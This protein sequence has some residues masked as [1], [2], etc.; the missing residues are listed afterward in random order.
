[1]S[2]FSP[3]GPALLELPTALGARRVKRRYNMTLDPE[4]VRR[5]DALAARLGVSR[6]ELVAFCFNRFES[7]Y[8]IAGGE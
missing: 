6:S 8:R 5:M 3:S 2:D 1:M 4:D 7:D